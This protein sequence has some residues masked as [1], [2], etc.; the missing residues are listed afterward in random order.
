MNSKN[1][2]K[3]KVYGRKDRIS[4]HHKMRIDRFVLAGSKTCKF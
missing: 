3:M 1:L 4:K 2:E